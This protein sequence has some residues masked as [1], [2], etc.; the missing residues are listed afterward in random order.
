MLMIKALFLSVLFGCL[1]QPGWVG[2]KRPVEN[3]CFYKL[4]LRV[5]FQES[6]CQTYR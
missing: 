4:P 1:W 2:L 6:V 3:G 5:D